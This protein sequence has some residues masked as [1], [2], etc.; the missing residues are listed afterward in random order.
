MKDITPVVKVAKRIESLLV[1]KYGAEGRGLHEKFTSV[2]NRVPA[3]LHK[4]IRY[5]ATVRNKAVHEDD[6]ELDDAQGFLS[7]AERVARALEEAPVKRAGLSLGGSFRSAWRFLVVSTKQVLYA[8]V[9]LLVGGIT[10]VMFS[11]PAT[12]GAASATRTP[13]ASSTPPA[14]QTPKTGKGAGT[15]PPAEALSNDVGKR[16]AQGKHV[17]LD[18]PLLK[19]EKISLSFIKGDFGDLEPRVELTVKN[20][21]GKT[22]ASAS[23][24]VRLFIDSQPGPVIDD[25]RSSQGLF[26]H[27]GEKGLKAG[28]SVMDIPLVREKD[29]WLRPDIVNARRWQLVLRHTTVRDGSN[30]S[31]DVQAPPFRSLPDTSPIYTAPAAPAPARALD[32]VDF[33]A[34]LRQGVSASAGNDVLSLRNP[35]VKLVKGSFDRLQ[36]VIE[37]DATNIGAR[38][39]SLARLQVRMYLDGQL[40]PVRATDDGS[41]GP[42]R[43]PSASPGPLYVFFGSRGLTPG[44]TQKVE[45]RLDDAWVSPDVLN[46]TSLTVLLRVVETQDGLKKPYGGKGQGMP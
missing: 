30:K 21:S 39:L 32:A 12:R 36:P 19:V 23:Y 6:Y 44:Q 33:S 28:A 8:I 46:A 14:S 20:T 25:S 18:S 7:Q 29:D 42:F 35:K 43:G 26:L 24:E 11:Q 27:F 15:A 37:L 31:M 2:Q 4:T 10:F 16:F 40:T 34:A 41:G 45:L 38:T 5:V 3:E 9:L 22:L 13:T 1:E 17:A